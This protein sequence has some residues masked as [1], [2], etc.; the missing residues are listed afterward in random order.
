MHCRQ[1]SNNDWK[2]VED[3]MEKTFSSWADKHMSVWG[4]GEISANQLC[5]NKPNN[6]CAHIFQSAEGSA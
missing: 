2:M 6:A 1:F 3:R 5:P 4:E